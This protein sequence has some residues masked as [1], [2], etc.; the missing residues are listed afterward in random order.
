MFLH[1]FKLKK[2][3]RREKINPVRTMFN[4]A[5]KITDRMGDPIKKKKKKKKSSKKSLTLRPF[6]NSDKVVTSQKGLD[7]AVGCDDDVEEDQVTVLSGKAW[8]FYL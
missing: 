7:V 8:P 3:F 1:N 4:T 5:I 6:H 2:C